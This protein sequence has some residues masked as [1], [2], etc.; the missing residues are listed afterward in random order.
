MR[1]PVLII[2]ATGGV[3]SALARRLRAE[4]RNLALIGRDANRLLPFA[5]ELEVPAHTAD[6]TDEAVLR[7]AIGRA[8]SEGCS[9]LA[10]CVGTLK[11]GPL[12]NITAAEMLATFAVHAAGAAVA[13]AA[14]APFL[15]QAGGAVVLFS[16]VAVAQGFANHA[17]VS[18]AKGA[19]EG[20]C[21][22]AAAELAPKVRVNCIAPSL[23][24]TPMAAGLLGNAQ[25][26]GA[27][28]AAHPLGRVGEAED[29]AAL[30]AFLL[31]SQA[32]W[33]TGQILPVDGGRS[34]L[35]IRGQ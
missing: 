27:I 8:A 2:G 33:I 26:A 24:R 28:A 34:S 18:A 3:G 35:R 31:G 29:I 16:S 12:S 22:S 5:A 11:L 23:T 7:D 25:V 19:V 21:R 6:V 32:G 1:E 20:L 17:A 30:A 9:G 14:A 10:Y 15:K 4:G 13:L